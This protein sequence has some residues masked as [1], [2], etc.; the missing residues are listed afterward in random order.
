LPHVRCFPFC[1]NPWPDA[2][3]EAVVELKQFMLSVYDNAAHKEQFPTPPH[4]L[5]GPASDVRKRCK[6]FCDKFP[7]RNAW[8]RYEDQVKTATTASEKVI[9]VILEKHFGMHALHPGR[10]PQQWK[11][12]GGLKEHNYPPTDVD[13][14]MSSRDV[15]EKCSIKHPKLRREHDLFNYAALY[16]VICK[17]HKCDP[18]YCLKQITHF[19]KYDKEKHPHVDESQILDRGNGQVFAVT[20]HKCRF[21]FGKKREYDPSGENDLTRGKPP[22]LKPTLTTDNNGMVVM[23]MRRNNPRTTQE[24]QISFHW[25]ANSNTVPLFLIPSPEHHL[26]G[27]SK[28][29]FIQRLNNLDFAGFAG[30]DADSAHLIIEQYLNK[31]TFKPHKSS[32]SSDIAKRSLTQAYCNDHLN[33]GM[34]IGNLIG[35]HMYE[36]TNSESMT[37]QQVAFADAGGRQM[38]SSRKSPRKCSLSSIGLRGMDPSASGRNAF[39]WH[40]IMSRYK[41]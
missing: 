19:T 37:S 2:I 7:L 27:L 41:S 15:V 3:N 28:E 16:T 18:R 31:Y 23:D 21:H 20:E 5:T 9:G 22:V 38:R 29:D 36:I 24:P 10:F 14:M 26:H 1:P 39:T 40:N 25:G 6:M 12:P 13:N 34:K 35:K 33:E 8:K 17:S 32:A 30:L 4:L 11:M